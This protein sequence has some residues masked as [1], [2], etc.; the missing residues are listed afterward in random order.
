MQACCAARQM[1]SALGPL[2]GFFTALLVVSLIQGLIVHGLA[3]S[4]NLTWEIAEQIMWVAV[5]L[6]TPNRAQGKLRL[7]VPTHIIQGHQFPV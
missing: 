3:K 4:N 5:A 7:E 1:S 6:D 2:L